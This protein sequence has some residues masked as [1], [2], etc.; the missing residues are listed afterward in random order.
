MTGSAA[1]CN[2]QC[3]NTPI[4]S[5]TGGDG[6]CPAGCHANND[7]DCSPV[8]GNG[9]TEPGETCDDGN[10]LDGDGCDSSCQLEAVPTVFR[11]SDL[12]LR[13][14]HVY[15]RVLFWCNDVTDT[16]VGGFS[17]N[18]E[19]HTAI[20]TDDD[21]DGLLDMSFLLIMRPLTQSVPGGSPIDVT[22]GDCTDPMAGTTCDA[23]PADFQ[24]T[25]YTNGNSGNCLEPIPGTTG[26]YTPGISSPGPVCFST[27]PFLLTLDFGGIQIPLTDVQ[28][29]ATYVG[30][31]ATQ[32]SNGLMR[33]F[34]SAADANA[35]ILPASLPL[36]GGDPLSSVL[37]GGSGSCRSGT[38]DSNNG[39]PG[40]WFYLN[41]PANV[42]T[43]IGP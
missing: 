20:T 10:L 22:V 6:C 11:L 39:V 14:P 15:V 23:D 8:C 28:V 16:P 36:I 19:L 30:S 4:T 1:A 42:V 7:T 26:G 21:T 2:V 18:G 12:D 17:V 40:W 25:N 3:T 27:A 34:I 37:P 38:L 31:P 43:Y 35:T 5:C 41:F 29:G 13:D 32:L 33:G 9:I 24:S